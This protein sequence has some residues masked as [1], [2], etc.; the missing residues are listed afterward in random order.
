MVRERVRE[1]G[2][3]GLGCVW[4]RVIPIV[5]FCCFCFHFV[6]RLGSALTYS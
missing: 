3:L 1:V 5:W 2:G 6:G 4:E